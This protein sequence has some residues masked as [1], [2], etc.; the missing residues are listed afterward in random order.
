M[1]VVCVLSMALVCAMGMVQA[2][3]AHP[4]D[5]TT[6]HHVC[7]ICSTAH[8]GLNMQAPVD[9]AGHGCCRAGDSCSGI[10]ADIP[11]SRHSVHSS[12]TGVLILR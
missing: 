10:R 12:S 3:H 9:R 7:S 2:V 8:A 6:S 11:S 4:D 1:R 5:S